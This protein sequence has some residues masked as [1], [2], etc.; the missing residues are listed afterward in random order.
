MLTPTGDN[1]SSYH[2]ENRTLRASTLSEIRSL[3]QNTIT[4]NINV[5]ELRMTEHTA[6]KQIERGEYG[7]KVQF[8]V[9]PSNRL[10]RV[11]KHQKSSYNYLDTR[12]SSRNLLIGCYCYRWPSRYTRFVQTEF[13]Q[14]IRSL[15]EANKYC[16]GFRDFDDLMHAS[17]E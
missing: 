3:T 11:V 1:G 15:M 7:A 12:H 8:Y 9:R 10:I 16:R 14:C 13:R 5:S 2:Q 4:N 6:K 17:I